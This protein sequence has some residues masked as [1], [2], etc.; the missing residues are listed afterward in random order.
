MPNYTEKPVFS[1]LITPQRSIGAKGLKA[2]LIAYIAASTCAAIPFIAMGLWPVAGFFGVDILALGIAFYINTLQA[3]S[4]EEI[5]LM[6]SE[7]VLRQ[8]SHRGHL[9]E[10]H[11]NP[12]W[13]K[14]QTEHDEDFGLQKIEIFNRNQRI[15]IANEL[16]PEERQN[17]LNQLQIALGQIKK[18]I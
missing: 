11:F 15:T 8:F 18:H 9:K 7:L 10:W 14:L 6:P 1:A 2:V 13:I 12:L 17:F 4:S 3:K 5:L 16:S